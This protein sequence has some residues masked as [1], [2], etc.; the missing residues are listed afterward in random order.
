[1][2]NNGGPTD[3]I[4]LL[5]DSL[6]INAGDP[7]NPPERDQRDYDRINAPDI[8]AFELGAT[9]PKTLANISTRLLVETGDNVLIGGFIVTG[10]DRKKVLLRAI[11]PSLPLTGFLANPVLEL[12]GQTGN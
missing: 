12:H 2:Q 11:G 8:G 10:S 1:M 3:T 9:I 6:A 4:A 5:P 7:V